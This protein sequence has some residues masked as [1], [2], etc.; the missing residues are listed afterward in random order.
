[1]ILFVESLPFRL[2]QNSVGAAQSRRSIG[3]EHRLEAYATLRLGLA[4]QA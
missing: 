1:M 4:K 3:A 2:W